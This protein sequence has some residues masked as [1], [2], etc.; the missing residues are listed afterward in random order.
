LPFCI[1]CPLLGARTESLKAWR[2]GLLRLPIIR[3]PLHRHS[4]IE[5]GRYKNYLQV[6]SRNAPVPKLRL[7]RLF[8]PERD[9]R[10]A[11]RLGT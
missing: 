10:R 3:I 8:S 4:S 7:L 11:C 2:E 1:L 5:A 9:S 6:G